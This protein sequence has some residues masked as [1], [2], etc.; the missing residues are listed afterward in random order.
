MLHHVYGGAPVQRMTGMGMPQP[1]AQSGRSVGFAHWARWGCAAGSQ[2]ARRCL[3]NGMEGLLEQYR[4]GKGLPGAISSLTFAKWEHIMVTIQDLAKEREQTGEQRGILLTLTE[5]VA[6]HWGEAVAADFRDQLSGQARPCPRCRTC[7]DGMSGTNRRCPQPV[8]TSK[9]RTL[10]TPNRAGGVL[11][12][13]VPAHACG[14]ICAANRPSQP[15]FRCQRCDFQ[16]HA[17]HNAALNI[18]GR[19]VRPVAR[20]TGATARREA[21]PSG[22]SLTREQDIP[23]A[24]YSSITAASTDHPAMVELRRLLELG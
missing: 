14:H 23:E 8:M 1:I 10:L 13:L 12:R 6:L 2:V 3:L 17:D 24:V 9:A 7:G 22:T 21:F 11:G 16:L 4:E 19:Y 15:V 18:L 20:G 5:Y